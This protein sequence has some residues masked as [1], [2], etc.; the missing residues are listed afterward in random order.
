M[1]AV[2]QTQIVRICG[3]EL[4]G[5]YGEL[6]QKCLRH[7]GQRQ[8]SFIGAALCGHGD[9]QLRTHIFHVIELFQL[10]QRVIGDFRL[11]AFLVKGVDRDG[12]HGARFLVELLGLAAH[13]EAQTHH[14]EYR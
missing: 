11:V 3:R 13:T 6:L 4:T 12:L 9:I 5:F 2:D 1:I 10:F 8:I 14:H 7:A